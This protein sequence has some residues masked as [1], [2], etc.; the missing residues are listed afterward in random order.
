MADSQT[1]NFAG[2]TTEQIQS[3][4]YYL[5]FIILGVVAVILIGFFIWKIVQNAKYKVQVTMFDETNEQTI[6]V[7]DVAKFSV[8]DNTEML[9]FKNINKYSPKF[10]PRFF[11]MLRKYTFWGIKYVQSLTVY[12]KGDKIVPL[13]VKSNPGIVA[14]D[15]DAW[16]YLVQRLRMN[17]AKYEKQQELMRILPFIALGSVVLMFILGNLFWGMHVEKVATAILDKASEI[18]KLTVQNA[19][20]MQI[21][22]P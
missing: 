15:Y 17:Q 20:A 13:M 12:K 16:N 11:S 1:L 2:L 18:A 10:E 5:F 7:H 14:I 6:K 21:I 9:H 22:T 19:G 3:G 4:S 8:I